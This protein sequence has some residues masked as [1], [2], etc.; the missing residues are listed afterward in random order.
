MNDQD[1]Q[2]V[3]QCARKAGITDQKTIN[4]IAKELDGVVRADR[5]ILGKWHVENNM[6]VL[7]DQ[8]RADRAWI[9]SHL[10]PIK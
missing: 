4:R 5:S 1:Y 9:Q 7:D 8:T 2:V 6:I 3:E 10:S